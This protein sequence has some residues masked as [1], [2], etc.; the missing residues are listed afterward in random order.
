MSPKPILRMRFFAALVFLLAFSAAAGAATVTREVHKVFPMPLSGQVMLENING[1]VEVAGWDEEKVEVSAR[2][3]VRHSSRRRAEEYLKEVEIYFDRDGD[4][5]HIDVDYPGRGGSSLLSWL[6]GHA[7][8]SVSIQFEVKVPR[9]IDLD[10]R[11]VNGSIDIADVEGDIE[12]RTTNGTIKIANA[13]GRVDCRTVNGRISVQLD[14]V[15]PFDEITLRTVNGRIQLAVPKDIRADI[16][17]STV[18]GSI[19]SDLPIEL[20]GKISR[21][22]LHGKINGGGGRITLKTVNGSIILTAQ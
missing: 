3:R 22:S 17:A 1:A 18:N 11:T 10:L 7:K 14:Q 16:E 13:R 5:L 15:H 12:A 20:I 8:P 19:S 2:I 9:K 6:F 21:R 4:Y